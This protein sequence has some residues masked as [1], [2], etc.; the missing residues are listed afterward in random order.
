MATRPVVLLHGYSD[1]GRSYRRWREILGAEGYELHEIHT[2]NYETLT[3]EISLDDI[4]EGFDRALRIEAG[5]DEDQDFDAIVHS[6]GML[7]LRAW[8]SR[9]AARRSRLKHLIGLAPATFGSPLA[10][11]GRSWLGAVFKGRKEFGPDFLEAGDL[12]LDGLELGSAFTWDLAHADLLDEQPFYGPGA[13]TPFVFVFCGDQGYGGLRRFIHEPGTDGTVRWA[14]CPLTTRKI[15]LDLSLRPLPDP[16]DRFRIVPK[17][18]RRDAD[19]PLI[20]IAGA[21]HGTILRDPPPNLLAMIIAALRVA[22][23]AGLEQWYGRQDVKDALANRATMHAYQQFIVRL[24][25]ERD[26]GVTD[27]NL[28]LFTRDAAGRAHRLDGFDDAVHVY[29]QDKSLRCFHVDLKAL[30]PEKLT[31]L[32]LRFIASSGTALV[33]YH[34]HGSQK[35]KEEGRKAA[36]AKWDGMFDISR[37]VQ[38]KG[39]KF[40]FP[41]TTTL[42]QIMLDREPMPL[43]GRNKVFWFEG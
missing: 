4:A 36:S 40:F 16:E 6:T 19:A 11:K 25:D 10:H 32:W 21:N 28:E 1:R 3:N 14:G 13:D 2:A 7:V 9:Y 5:L 39:F 23:D 37:T 24:I 31:N 17:G 41:F 22:S 33:G 29:A 27:Y 15:E 42:I 35:V 34:G 8:L 20:P 18:D 26:D 12:V 30:R 38:D 43:A